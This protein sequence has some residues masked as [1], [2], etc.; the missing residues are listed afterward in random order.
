VNTFL[1]H[2]LPRATDG[3][4]QFA[5]WDARGRWDD[6]KLAYCMEPGHYAVHAAAVPFAIRD[7]GSYK[8]CTHFRLENDHHQ[9][10]YV[11]CQSVAPDGT[12]RPEAEGGGGPIPISAPSTLALMLAAAVALHYA[13]RRRWQ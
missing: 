6:W 1:V 9:D 10:L 3:T 2:Q 8:E 7:V 11:T 4:Q 5:V 12:P 13:T